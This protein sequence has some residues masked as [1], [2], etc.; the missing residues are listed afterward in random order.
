[1]EGI[2]NT[3]ISNERLTLT[4]LREDLRS[5]K[6]LLG[7][8]QLGVSAERYTLDVS[9]LVFELMGCS[10]S[11]ANA[12]MDVYR[13]AM[14]LAVTIQDVEEADTLEKMAR[15]AYKKLLAAKQSL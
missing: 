7:L 5:N 15:E 4:L 11:E 1:M 10:E 9:D 8:E 6:L 12:L 13:E 2:E 14:D 3:G